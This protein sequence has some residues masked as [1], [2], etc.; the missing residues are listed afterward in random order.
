MARAIGQRGEPAVFE[1]GKVIEISADHIARLPDQARV[2]ERSGQRL[3]RGAQHRALDG[4]GVVDAVH[5][6]AVLLGLHVRDHAHQLQ[7]MPDA[8]EAAVARD[9]EAIGKR[10]LAILHRLEG[11]GLDAHGGIDHQRLLVHEGDAALAVV[12]LAVI[13]LA[14]LRH[15]DCTIDQAD[16]RVVL[17]HRQAVKVPVLAEHIEDFLIVLFRGHRWRGDAEILGTGLPEAGTSQV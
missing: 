5:D 4:A 17:G 1:R 3:T 14:H 16:R 13:G 15:E 10:F 2:A 9:D 6:L 8:K 11:Q 7:A 12:Q